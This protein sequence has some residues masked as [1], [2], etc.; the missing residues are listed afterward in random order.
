MVIK[1]I[2][3]QRKNG[4]KSKKGEKQGSGSNFF[5]SNQGER[6]TGK[7]RGEETGRSSSKRQ[8]QGGNIGWPKPQRR[9]TWEGDLGGT[10]GKGLNS[11]YLRPV[12]GK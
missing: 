12:F 1:S 5:L 7:A 4:K 2:K 9:I 3:S 6:G 11:C 8:L 10:R